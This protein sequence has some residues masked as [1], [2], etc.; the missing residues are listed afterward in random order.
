LNDSSLT[1]DRQRAVVDD[2]V[3]R[4][5]LTFR[6]ADKGETGL[7][8]AIDSAIF[9][10]DSLELERAPAGELEAAVEAKDVYLFHLG[11]RPVGYLHLD[12]TSPLK[13]YIS[14]FGVV[15]ERQNDRLGTAMVTLTTDLLRNERDDRPIY[16]VTSP[17]NIRMLRLLFRIDFAGRW[18]LPDFFGPGRHRIGCQLVHPVTRADDHRARSCPDARQVVAMEDLAGLGELLEKNWLIRKVW[19]EEDGSFFEL[20]APESAAVPDCPRPSSSGKPVP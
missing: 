8:R 5:S 17:R 11:H 15:P 3:A 4:A 16:T 12:R 20:N 6:L 2:P 14:G 19:R 9:P 10:P 18:V 1:V 13:I 7:V